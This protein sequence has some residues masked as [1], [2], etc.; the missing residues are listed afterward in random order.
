MYT[1]IVICVYMYIYIYIYTRIYIYI[2]TVIFIY[3]HIHT[4]YIHTLCTLYLYTYTWIYIYIVIIYTH[5]FSAA[6]Q[7][8][9]KLSIMSRH[10]DICQSLWGTERRILE[11]WS[12]WQQAAQ[13]PQAL[14]FSLR[15]ATSEVGNMA[16]LVGWN[17]ALM[18]PYIGDSN[19]NWW[20]HIF[21][22]PSSTSSVGFI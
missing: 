7:S 1:Y 2:Y 16:L 9:S 10:M 12:W 4:Y 11:V 15:F 14:H 3:I 6:A 21:Q 19:P 8:P 20:T 18:F 5:T 13:V 22:P 17:M